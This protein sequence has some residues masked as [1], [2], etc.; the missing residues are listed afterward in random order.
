MN[1]IRRKR[2]SKIILERSLLSLFVVLLVCCTA[3]SAFSG[4]LKLVA[5]GVSGLA[6]AD[7]NVFFL[8]EDG[9]KVLWSPLDKLEQA[10][11]NASTEPYTLNEAK[12]SGFPSTN[13]DDSWEALTFSSDGEHAYFAYENSR[14]GEYLIYR[15]KVTKEEEAYKF[16]VDSEPLWNDDSKLSVVRRQKRLK[17]NG[18]GPVAYDNWNHGFESLQWLPVRERLLTIHEISK[19]KPQLVSRDGNAESLALSDH[20]YRLSDIS[21]WPKAPES[22]FIATSFCWERDPSEFCSGDGGK[23]ALHLVALTLTDSAL[24][25]ESR[26]ENLRSAW[27]IW[28]PKKNKNVDYNAEGILMTENYVLVVN[29]SSNPRDTPT[30]LRRIPLENLRFGDQTG[31]EWYNNCLKW[32]ERSNRSANFSSWLYSTVREGPASGPPSAARP[33]SESLP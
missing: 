29:D 24:H 16:E 22:C 5:D 14:D 13:G 26:T 19:I 1:R 11:G 7:G 8:E 33:T 17:V 10:F 4:T 28:H 15:A 25:V 12:I 30:I 21:G 9:P 32:T 2:Q 3:P 27:R 6:L 23:S 20:M 18:E 31:I